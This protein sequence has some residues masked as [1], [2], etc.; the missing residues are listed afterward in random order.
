MH[1]SCVSFLAVL[2][3]SVAALNLLSSRSESEC[4]ISLGQ[5]VDC[6]ADSCVMCDKAAASCT[7]NTSTGTVNCV[8]NNPSE[9]SIQNCGECQLCSATNFIYPLENRSEL[10][11]R[12]VP[13]GGQPCS[14]HD[15][16]PQCLASE[17]ITTEQLQVQDPRDQSIDASC[18]CYET[19]HCVEQM[20]INLTTSET[21]NLTNT[22]QEGTYL[23]TH[24]VN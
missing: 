18:A 21:N 14:F 12:C 9:C 2:L 1:G 3:L 20:V 4:A 15:A 7:V 22:T 6:I 23:C 5:P 10:T 24:T 17:S 11:S 16:N 8:L 13:L 19:E